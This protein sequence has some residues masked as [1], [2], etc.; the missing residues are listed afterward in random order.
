MKDNHAIFIAG[1]AYLG[2]SSE[3]IIILARDNFFI[4]TVNAVISAPSNHLEFTGSDAD[5]KNIVHYP[6]I[7][8]QTSKNN[9]IR[10]RRQR[11]KNS[12]FRRNGDNFFVFG[13]YIKRASEE[14][15]NVRN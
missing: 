8:I 15:I 14:R 10:C 1:F 7:K 13:K 2:K 4:I 11:R 6:V 5:F 12:N 9:P 3:E